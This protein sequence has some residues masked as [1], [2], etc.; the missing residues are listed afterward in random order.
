MRSRTWQQWLGKC[1]TEAWARSFILVSQVGSWAQHLGHLTLL[2]QAH[3]H[4][5]GLK[6][7]YLKFKQLALWKVAGDCFTWPHGCSCTFIINEK[8]PIE[9]DSYVWSANNPHFFSDCNLSHRST[10]FT[11]KLG[12]RLELSP[13]ESREDSEGPV[14]FKTQ[15]S[16][17]SL[18]LC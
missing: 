10:V 7:E 8:L 17:G 13:W 9:R 5:A 3:Y 12:K 2:P 6:A 18:H 15:Q 14:F 1:Q 16:L 4:V 11:T